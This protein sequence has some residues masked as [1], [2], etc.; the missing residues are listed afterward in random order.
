MKSAIRKHLRD[1]AAI[2]VLVL[3]AGFVG[4]YVLAHQRTTLPA[5][6]PMFGKQVFVLK[7]QFSTAQAITPGQGQT[8][9][10]AGV[11]IGQITN[12]DLVKGR[13]IV[14][15][16]LDPKYSHRVYPNATMLLR[17]KTGL[18][19]MVVELNPG[20]RAAG[21][22]VKDGYTVPV[23]NTLP[24]VNLDEFLSVLDGDTR[25]YL[26]LLLN[27]GA[28][29]LSN[30]GTTL[31]Q[32]FRRFEPTARDTA[33]ITKLLGQRRQYIQ[34]SIHNFGVFANALAARDQQ[35][36]T[37][38]EN[39]NTVFRHFANQD[40]NLQRT[41]QLLPAALRDTNAALAQAKAFAD[42]AGPALG[43]LRPGAR[44]LGPSLVESRPFFRET[45]PIVQNQL[46]PFT[47]VATPVVK[48]LRPAAADFA[49]ATPNLTTTFRVLN[50][51]L[52][53]LAYNPAG[54][55]EGYLFYLAWLNHIS[56]SI[57]SAQDAE[58]PIRRGT[59]MISCLNLASLNAP[60]IN[61]SPAYSGLRL[62]AQLVNGPNFTVRNLGPYCTK[63]DLAPPQP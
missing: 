24:D 33:Q 44:A 39:S 62:L 54:S 7:G 47:R 36:G 28:E 46:R 38:V 19:D 13:A 16:H 22:A 60:T 5:W 56:N 18:K 55:R 15:M 43:A 10:I 6:V 29:G 58:G 48:Q 49:A 59:L 2:V 12:V 14:T 63:N 27:G 11:Q 23:S 35:L 57:F 41:I 50:A 51:F 32:V 21:P 45:T 20:T 9:D 42:Q 34:R 61:P 40:V 26:D 37:F 53:G 52:N 4:L 17:P 8:I 3:I 31:A 1:F 25:T 30:D